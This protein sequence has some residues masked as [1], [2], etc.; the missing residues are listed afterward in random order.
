MKRNKL[1]F[2]SLS[3]LS[4]IRKKKEV[5]NGAYGRSLPVPSGLPHNRLHKEIVVTVC[6]K[7]VYCFYRLLN[8][9]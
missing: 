1:F 2:F 6:E 7:K 5:K 8:G 4:V 9:E 3:P